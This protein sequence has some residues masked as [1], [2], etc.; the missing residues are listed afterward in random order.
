MNLH[1]VRLHRVVTL[2]SEVDRERIATRNV[3]LQSKLS[4]QVLL[5][6]LLVSSRSATFH[7]H[8]AAVLMSKESEH[9]TILPFRAHHPHHN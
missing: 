4:V 8:R 1:W 2:A 5:L 3:C 6:M 9:V 7:Q